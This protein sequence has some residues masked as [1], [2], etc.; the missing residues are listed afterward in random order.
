MIQGIICPRTQYN[1]VECL[2]QM[3]V[4]IKPIIE[5]AQRKL[6]KGSNSQILNV[7]F[8]IRCQMEDRNNS[9]NPDPLNMEICPK[10]GRSY[11]FFDAYELMAYKVSMALNDNVIPDFMPYFYIHLQDAV[12]PYFKVNASETKFLNDILKEDLRKENKKFKNFGDVFL[13]PQ[14]I[15]VKIERPGTSPKTKV[16]VHELLDLTEFGGS[17]YQLF[18]VVQTKQPGR[19]NCL[20][21]SIRDT[22]GWI[23]IDNKEVSKYDE[24]VLTKETSSS[25]TPC[26]F[27]GFIQGKSNIDTFRPGQSVEMSMLSSTAAA[28][29]QNM[30]A[31]RGMEDNEQ[32]EPKSV[33]MKVFNPITMAFEDQ[34]PFMFS[35]TSEFKKQIKALRGNLEAKGFQDV[36]ISY[37][38]EGETK[39]NDL[40]AIIPSS[41]AE[42]LGNAVGSE[43]F[44]NKFIEM[45]PV[46]VKITCLTKPDFYTINVQFADTQRIS[47]L[48]EFINEALEKTLSLQECNRPVYY[49]DGE[50]YRIADDSKKINEYDPLE[51]F[52]TNDGHPP[53]GSNVVL[54]RFLDIKPRYKAFDDQFSFNTHHTVRNVKEFAQDKYGISDIDLFT[55]DPSAPCLNVFHPRMPMTDLAKVKTPLFAQTKLKLKPDSSVLNFVIA[56]ELDPLKIKTDAF[57]LAFDNFEKWSEISP[58]VKKALAAKKIDYLYV[59]KNGQKVQLKD[60]MQAKELTKGVFFVKASN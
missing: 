36:C 55:F 31:E 5:K 10:V 27:L 16:K 13:P 14:L 11:S 38:E 1:G 18:M 30:I 12:I 45:K 3:I 35:S 51:F 47:D 20:I 9:I 56:D 4:R 26:I 42:I 41:G 24:F 15:F 44:V 2:A 58:K 48:R 32:F 52:F 46:E 60:N 23:R 39:Y 49:W 25:A 33:G 7:L 22:K 29:H 43:D 28:Q 57:R 21:M 59:I 19:S 53:A 6:E 34:P 50:V 54:I 40:G 17:T 37:K 8:D